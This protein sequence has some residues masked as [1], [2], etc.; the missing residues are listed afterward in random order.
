M[1]YLNRTSRVAESFFR[2]VC[3][4]SSFRGVKSSK[5]NQCAF[6]PYVG[7]PLVAMCSS[8]KVH[9]K[10]SR[11]T[12][13]FHLSQI[14]SIY[15]MIYISEIRK[16]IICFIPVNMVYVKPRPLACYVEP[17]NSVQAVLPIIEPRPYIPASG[18][19]ATTR[20]VNSSCFEFSL[21]YSG[22]R[23]VLEKFTNSIRGNIGLSH[24][25]V[26]SKQWFGQKTSSVSAL[27]GL[28][29]FSEPWRI[30]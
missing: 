28:C 22:F 5:V 14:L 3:G 30:L 12:H 29:Y 1:K 13:L 17:C 11:F 16:T 21:K 18:I 27:A 7:S 24:A 19:N 25:V 23:V 6:N 15:S 4:L 26:P 9:T 8:Y 2:Y 10:K 20:Y